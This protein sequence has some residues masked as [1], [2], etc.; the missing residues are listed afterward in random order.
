MK[1]FMFFPT[2]KMFL[3]EKALIKQLFYAIIHKKSKAFLNAEKD[4]NG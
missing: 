4:K 3:S 1:T 2:Q